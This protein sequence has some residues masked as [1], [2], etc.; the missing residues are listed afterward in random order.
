MSK[1]AKYQSLPVEDRFK[2][3]AYAF[4]LVLVQIA[5]SWF[6]YQKVYTF[7]VSHPR[8]RDLFPGQ[9]GESLK[10]AKHYS[11]M[12]SIAARYGLFRATCLRQA[13]LVFWLLRRRGIQTDL[14]I[15]VRREGESIFAHAWL[16]YGE[17]V[18]TEGSLVE[19]NFSAFEDLPGVQ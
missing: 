16:N 9:E 15:G 2:L 19:K 3:I 14:R 4:L 10:V 11:Y 5:L 8:K 1:W 12:V 7:L 13:L 6:G 18:I 17:D